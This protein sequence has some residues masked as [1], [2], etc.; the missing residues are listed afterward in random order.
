MMDE[1]FISGFISVQLV[2]CLRASNN[3]WWSI[4]GTVFVVIYDFTIKC[5]KNFANIFLYWWRPLG[6]PPLCDSSSIY[7][8][9]SKFE[10]LRFRHSLNSL[11]TNNW[12]RINHRMWCDIQQKN[13]VTQLWTGNKFKDIKIFIDN[14]HKNSVQ[15]KFMIS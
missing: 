2:I 13:V 15:G 1:G 6:R 11:K 12:L 7:F 14:Q 8:R 4:N 10:M 3:W 5:N 9:D